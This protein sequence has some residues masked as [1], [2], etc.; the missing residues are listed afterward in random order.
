MSG[1]ETSESLRDMCG[2]KLAAFDPWQ[3]G[4]AHTSEEE[5]LFKA[6]QRL[7]AAGVRSYR[8]ITVAPPMIRR[9][10]V[11]GELCTPP[12]LARLA[13]C[14]QEPYADGAE[15]VGGEPVNL[16]AS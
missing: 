7:V 5:D 1:R 4:G 10:P 15:P 8:L 3:R 13:R 9:G 11:A 2:W 14:G 12:L 16:V 6:V